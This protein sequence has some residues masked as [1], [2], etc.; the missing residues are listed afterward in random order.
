MLEFQKKIM[1]VLDCEHNTY[2][3]SEACMDDRNDQIE[4]ILKSKAEKVFHS[5]NRKLARFHQTSEVLKMVRLL[6]N[7]QIPFEQFSKELAL[8]IFE[9]KMEFGKFQLSDLVIALVKKDDR[10]YVLI[11]DNHCN[12]GWT[13]TVLQDEGHIKN[14]IIPYKALISSTLTTKDS[15]VLIELYDE[16]IHTIEKPFTLHEQTMYFYSD[17]VLDSTAKLSYQESMKNVTDLTQS[18]TNKYDLEQVSIMPKM[19]SYVVDNVEENIPI[20]V[21]DMAEELFADVPLA[22]EE[23]KEELDKLGVPKEIEVEYVKATK[24]SRMHKIKTDKGIEISIPVD[25]MNSTEFVEFF[26]QPDGTIAIQLKNI[27]HITSK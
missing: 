5:T 23:F 1:H 15:A 3:L 26:N 21:D 7:D 2:V 8:L 20:Q 19:K 24:A 16:S 6:Q 25:Y 9:K 27:T 13:H 12:E 11:L 4:K 10:R 17:V 14:D 18:L 22:K